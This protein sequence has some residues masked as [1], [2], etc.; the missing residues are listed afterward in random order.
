[1]TRPSLPLVPLLM[2]VMLVVFLLLPTLVILL[3][4]LSGGFF[5]ALLQP[6]VLDALKVS[7]VTTTITLL[8]TVGLGTPIAYLLARYRFRGKILLDTLLDLPIVLPPV[9]AG[10]GLLL[11]FGR[12]GL[13]GPALTLAGISIAFSPAAVVLAQLF[14]S[15]P[16][17]IRASKGGFL[18]IDRDIEAAARVDG[19]SNGQVFRFITWPLAFPFLLEGMVLAWA[20]ALGEFGATILFAGSLQGRTQTITLSIYAA[21]ESDLKPALVLS[22]VMVVVAFTMLGVV[23]RITARRSRGES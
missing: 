7:L 13:L 14:T 21:L 20:R 23:R 17:F 16:F 2:G 15:A 18:A 10:V 6:V 1:M 9:V 19:A 3:H 4:G 8:L 11:T 5:P 12:N 22:A